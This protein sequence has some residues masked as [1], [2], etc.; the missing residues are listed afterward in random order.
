MNSIV[1]RCSSSRAFAD[2]V[3]GH[4]L[5]LEGEVGPAPGFG[6]GFSQLDL[7]PADGADLPGGIDVEG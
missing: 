6:V 5:E 4:E 7:L 1:D 2:P 3:S